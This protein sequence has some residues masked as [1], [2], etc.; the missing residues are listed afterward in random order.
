MAITAALQAIYSD[1]DDTRLFYDCVQFFHPNFNLGTT[2]SVYP[3]TTIVPAATTTPAAIDYSG[4]S[5]FLVRDVVD[6]SYVI[7]D[8]STQTFTSYPFNVIQPQAGEDQQDIGVVLDNVSLEILSSIELAA[9]KP[10]IPIIMTFSVY[11]DGSTASQI[12]PI[13]LALTEVVVDMF[14]VSCKASRTD[15]FK[16]KFPF[17]D[18]TYYDTKFKGLLV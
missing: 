13:S 16:R 2:T 17:G 10:E 8:G 18:H 1:Y 6:H 3:E 5:F 7:A 12:T 15:L 14:T 11:M 4:Q 9:A